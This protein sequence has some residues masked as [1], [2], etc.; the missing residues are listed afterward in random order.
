MPAWSKD[1]KATKFPFEKNQSKIDLANILNKS[2]KEEIDSYLFYEL[3]NNKDSKLSP[4]F[5]NYLIQSE[6][7]KNRKGFYKTLEWARKDEQGR[8]KSLNIKDICD[9]YKKI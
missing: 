9:L 3:I 8:Y 7:N 4:I 1:C 2:L 6:D 5:F